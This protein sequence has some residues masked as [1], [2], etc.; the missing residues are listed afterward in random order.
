MTEP[1][2]FVNT[3]SAKS[4]YYVT[5][6]L[7]SETRYQHQASA[8]LLTPFK[9]NPNCREKEPDRLVFVIILGFL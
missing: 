3:D 4:K 9:S 1:F 6:E 2:V 7:H 5:S 8:A